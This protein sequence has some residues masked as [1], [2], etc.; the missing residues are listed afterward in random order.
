MEGVV[1]DWIWKCCYG[2]KKEVVKEKRKMESK[3]LRREVERLSMA[4]SQF[5]RWI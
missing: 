3:K 5:V 4:K 2:E 1:K